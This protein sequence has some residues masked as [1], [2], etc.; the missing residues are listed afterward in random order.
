MNF[1]QL[2]LFIYLYLHESLNNSVKTNSFSIS[3]NIEYIDNSLVNLFLKKLINSLLFFIFKPINNH[4]EIKEVC[5]KVCPSKKNSIFKFFYN[6]KSL[7]YRAY[8]WR[9]QNDSNIRL[10]EEIQRTYHFLKFILFYISTIIVIF[11]YY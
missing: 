4:K 3:S 2:Y 8:K 6:I 10:L 1:S 5:P 9:P 7:I 11:V